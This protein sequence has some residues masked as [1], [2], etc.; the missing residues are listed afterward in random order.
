MRAQVEMHLQLRV[1]GHRAEDALNA[2]TSHMAHGHMVAEILDIVKDF[3]AS[4]AAKYF[5]LLK[6]MGY[7]KVQFQGHLVLESFCTDRALKDDLH[8]LL[9]VVLADIVDFRRL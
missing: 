1:T 2:H 8:V 4:R 9:Q 7:S 6:A 3:N 5:C